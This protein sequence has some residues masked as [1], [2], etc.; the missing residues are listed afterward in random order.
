MKSLLSCGEVAIGGKTDEKD[1]YVEP[2][3]LINV[4]AT[5]PVMETEVSGCLL[6]I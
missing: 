4:K 6:I 1:N 3:V 2:T 5:D